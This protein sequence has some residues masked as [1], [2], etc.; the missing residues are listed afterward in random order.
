M[1]NQNTNIMNKHD[2]KIQKEVLRWQDAEPFDL[3]KNFHELYKEDNESHYFVRGTDFYLSDE[4]LAALT[5]G[6]NGVLKRVDLWFGLKKF[7]KKDITFAPILGLTFDKDGVEKSSFYHM[8]PTPMEKRVKLNLNSTEGSSVISVPFV[9]EVRNNWIDTTSEQ[10]AD[11]LTSQSVEGLKR[12]VVYQID[13]AGLEFLSTNREMLTGF[14]MYPGVDRNKSTPANISF[15]T[16]FGLQFSTLQ[17]T[18]RDVLFDSSGFGI[19]WKIGGDSGED[20]DELFLDFSKPCP[21]TC[22]PPPPPPPAE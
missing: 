22:W 18:A 19:S 4:G 12:I 2:K 16:V 5:D 15:I 8:L 11:T 6:E 10:I 14:K 17:D 1:Y 9:D 3:Y 7:E 21:P 13:G 20:D